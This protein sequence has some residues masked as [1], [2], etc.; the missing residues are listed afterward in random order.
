MLRAAAAARLLD[1]S[2]NL[3]PEAW[4]AWLRLGH[5][6]RGVL[7]RYK[8]EVDGP[9]FFLAER[10][11]R[12]PRA[13]LRATLNGF[14]EGL[15]ADDD[16]HALCRFPARLL[17]ALEHL[18]LSAEMLPRPAC[19]KFVEFLNKVQPNG[20]SIVFS[21]YDV[22][23]PASA[24]GHTLIRIHHAKRGQGAGE[25]LLDRAITYGANVDTNNAFAYAFKGLT[26][27]FQGSFQ[28]LPY[29]YKVREY[30]DYEARDTWEYALNL[31]PVELRRMVAHLWELGST[32]IDYY[33]LSDNC[34]HQLLRLLEVAAPWIH[35]VKK[36]RTPAL[37]ADIV[38]HIARHP[39][40]VSEV[41][42]RPSIRTQ[43]FARYKLLTRHEK[44]LVRRLAK[45]ADVPLDLP[46]ERRVM[47]LDT[48]ATLVHWRN[49]KDLTH[50]SAGKAAAR[51]HALELRRSAI[52]TPSAPLDTEQPAQKRPDLGHGSRRF[53]LASGYNQRHG[54]QLQLAYRVALHDLTDSSL[55]YPDLVAID[56]LDV[57][58]RISLEEGRFA[59]DDSHLLR[60]LSLHNFTRLEPGISW[61]VD[62][63]ANLIDDSSCR[64]CTVA[65]VKGGTGFAKAFFADAFTLYTLFEGAFWGSPELA[66]IG[67]SGVRLGVGTHAGL[68]LR[69]HPR[70]VLSASADW[71]WLPGQAPRQSLDQ[72]STLRFV[73]FGDF[74]I[75]AESRATLTQ[76][77]GLALIGVYH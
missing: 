73:A 52:R 61:E 72:R 30:N 13:E 23:S 44:A 11:R 37:P 71:F 39:G 8:S 70:L 15:G 2:Q 33:Y 35:L 65:R 28:S 68:R 22:S 1:A 53:E 43:F 12:D 14:L 60:I 19:A 40:L 6:Q 10:G 46:D 27:L 29:Y 77:E 38:K 47:V 56:F 48:A 50:G 75:G 66:G 63:G 3:T 62:V 31:S 20:A 41:Q 21:A 24:F 67:G 54:T 57:R 4:Q 32:Y 64:Q 17:W 59:V 69:L 55:G 9:S 58:L 18:P 51:K 5:Y 25:E 74:F 7:S 45:D 76:V 34:A 16:T 42:H 49:A 36:S 26:G